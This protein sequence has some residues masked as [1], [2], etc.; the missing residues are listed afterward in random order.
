M[1]LANNVPI[2]LDNQSGWDKR[3]Q[4]QVNIIV[5][6]TRRAM[7]AKAKQKRLPTPVISNP[8][9]RKYGRIL[10][11]RAY[12]YKDTI[13]ISFILDPVGFVP[14]GIYPL[15]ETKSKIDNAMLQGSNDT[16]HCDMT[17]SQLG[18]LAL[19]RIQNDNVLVEFV[20]SKEPWPVD[21]G[22]N[23]IKYSCY[24]RGNVYAK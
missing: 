4:E 13:S 22:G 3:Q 9:S 18:H 10:D 19:R 16:F 12:L 17:L 11:V 8:I 21:S 24:M 14:K 23:M 5:K 1:P 6:T 2:L 15:F 7:E 20:R